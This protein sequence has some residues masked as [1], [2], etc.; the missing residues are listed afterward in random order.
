MNIATKLRYGLARLLLKASGQTYNTLTFPG[1]QR[2]GDLLLSGF[3]ALTREGYRKNAVVF[4]CISALAFDFPEPP[5]LVYDEDS[6]DA[7][8]IPKHPLRKLLARPNAFMGERELWMYTMVY[9]AIGG[10]AYWHKVRNARGQV[11]ELW[12]YNALAIQPYSDPNTPNWIDHYVYTTPDGRQVAVPIED[13][14]HFKWPS[15]NIAQPQLAQP[16]L[17]AVSSE[18]GADNEMTLYLNSLM[19]NDAIPRTI[20]IQNPQRFMTPEEIERAKQQFR[21]NYGGDKRGGVLV[22][23]GG[24]SIERLGLNLQELAFDAMHKVPEKRIASAFRVPLSVAGV[25]DDPTYSNSEEAYNRYVRSTL[26]PLWKLADDEVQNSLG[27]EFGVWVER[28]LSKVAALQED[29]DKLW[30]RVDSAFQAGRLTLNQANQLCNLPAVAGGDVY[31]WAATVFPVPAAQIGAIA[32][33]EADAALNPP[34]LPA[35]VS[36]PPEQQQNAR[37]HQTESKSLS[38]A[39]RTARALQRIR[40]KLEPRFERALQAYF[41]D[42]ADTIV[43]RAEDSAKADELPG[44]EQLVLES[45]GVP[46]LELVQRY[47]LAI[48]EASWETWNLGLGIETAFEQSDP[49]VVR[50]MSGAATQVKNI[51]TTTLEAIRGVLTFGAEQGWSIGQLVRG[52]D[53]APGLRAVVEETYKG[54][55]RTIARTELGTAQQNCAV[56]RYEDAGVTKVMVLDGGGDDSDE[57]CN[58]LNNSV[59]T[60]AWAAANPLGHPNCTRCFAPYFE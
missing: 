53:G 16:P 46:L 28:D 3:E 51:T 10:N 11:I 18:V 49:A 8:V 42:L 20:L 2:A 32:R 45:D 27:D 55:A 4:A 17:L 43:Q 47:Y 19:Q 6:D 33:A 40:R 23:E 31:L 5:T 13:I 9:M 34:A 12:P 57:D 48:F 22:L 58:A 41:N 54:R 59:Q 21:A 37:A 35:P 30:A 24:T 50:A 36:Q 60:L 38:A 25:G 15:V 44:L 56:A 52:V 26:S 29:Q 14:V 39:R 7:Q 1:W